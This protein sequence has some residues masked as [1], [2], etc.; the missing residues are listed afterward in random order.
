MYQQE[1]QCDPLTQLL[2]LKQGK[3]HRRVKR[4]RRLK[5]PRY[6]EVQCCVECRPPPPCDWPRSAL[7]QPNKTTTRASL[8]LSSTPSTVS[9]THGWPKAHQ[10]LTGTINL[11]FVLPLL[12]FFILL[13]L[14]SCTV[15]VNKGVHFTGCWEETWTPPSWQHQSAD[16]SKWQP[17]CPRSKY[18][19][20]TEKGSC[21]DTTWVAM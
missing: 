4:R 13:R 16:R 17:L 19:S 15:T 3:R 6:C 8:W 18:Q 5:W 10:P 7:L 20:L 1:P 21:Q 11:T 2:T 9:A 14:S 12:T